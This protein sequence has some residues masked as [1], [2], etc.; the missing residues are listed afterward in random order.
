MAFAW[1]LN[2]FLVLIRVDLASSLSNTQKI[3]VSE[4]KR[5]EL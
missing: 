4:G 1:S 3:D 5:S 2:E